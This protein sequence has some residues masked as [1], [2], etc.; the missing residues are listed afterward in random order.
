[1]VTN[2][3]AAQAL[4]SGELTD[5]A[6]PV[7]S[8]KPFVLHL[9]FWKNCI[10]HALADTKLQ[11]GFR[12]Y[13]DGFSGCRISSFACLSLRFDEF[14]ESWKHELA[15][16]FNFSGSQIIEFVKELLYLRAFHAS[17]VCKMIEDF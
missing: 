4:T 3:S 9:F 2:V 5:G 10:L 7:G 15:V 8:Y 14:A 1:M 17:L 6:E 13:L 12:R 11:S 16:G